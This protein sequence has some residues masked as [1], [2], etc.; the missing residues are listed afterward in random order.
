MTTLFANCLDSFD[1]RFLF[2]FFDLL[3]LEWA[4][5]DVVGGLL[6]LV[7]LLFLNSILYKYLKYLN[8]VI[9]H[10][11]YCILPLWRELREFQCRLFEVKLSLLLKLL[12]FIIVHIFTYNFKILL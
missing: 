9:K 12:S 5:A 4:L 10:V 8:Y 2:L 1:L 7:F 6:P 11:T 3:L